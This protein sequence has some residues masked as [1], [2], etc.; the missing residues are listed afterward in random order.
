MTPAETA[1]ILRQL[2]EWRQGA[3][4]DPPAPLAVDKAIDAA[5]EMIE[6]L[7]SAESD[8]FE[9]ARLNGMGA[10]RE[11]ALLA[12]LEA[13][14]KSDAESI[15]MYRKARDE[16]DALRVENET[17]AANLR[18]K[19]STAGATYA[20]LIAERDAL[21]AKVSDLAIN[22]EYLGNLKKSYEEL[23]GELQDE[24]D[25]L[26]AKVEAMEKQ[27]P[28]MWANS[29]NIISARISTERGSAGDQHTCSETKTEYHDTPLYL[30]TGAQGG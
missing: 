28:A 12:K 26:R 30:A 24:R 20:H 23:I 13:A 27:E 10:S 4:V 17:L 15:A 11:A 16:R 25:R 9:Q 21:R 22:V 3:D 18:G 1:A 29:S 14:E 7:E 6:R 19:H 5:I 8:A 2:T